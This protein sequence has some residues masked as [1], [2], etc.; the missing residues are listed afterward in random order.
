MFCKCGQMP[1]FYPLPTWRVNR[2]CYTPKGFSRVKCLRCG[3]EWLTRKAYTK[4]IKN[5]DLTIKFK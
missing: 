4:Y 3:C 1:R 2:Y 5:Y